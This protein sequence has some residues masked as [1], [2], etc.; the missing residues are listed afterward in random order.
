MRGRKINS[1]D[2][3]MT[4]LGM[5]ESSSCSL[6]FYCSHG[7]GEHSYWDYINCELLKLIERPRL[8][9][10]LHQYKMYYESDTC[11]HLQFLFFFWDW[12]WLHKHKLPSK[13]ASS[14]HLL[15]T[16]NYILIKWNKWKT[17]KNHLKTRTCVRVLK[18]LIKAQHQKTKMSLLVK[19][20]AV[21]GEN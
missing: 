6:F 21:N 14:F 20:R 12:P 11:W 3:F 1:F 2:I 5:P 4:F 9:L 18:S 13:F 19:W 17:F 7:N 8:N 15:Y 10:F 16:E